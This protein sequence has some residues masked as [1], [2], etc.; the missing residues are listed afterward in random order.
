[1][2]LDNIKARLTALENGVFLEG[3]NKMDTL[4][5]GP[6]AAN[7]GLKNHDQM[8]FDLNQKTEDTFKEHQAKLTE[9]PAK[10]ASRSWT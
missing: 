9:K 6:E 8:L 4:N 3:T 7:M 5:L 10:A 1:M 2:E